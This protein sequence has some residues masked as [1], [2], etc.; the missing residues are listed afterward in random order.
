MGDGHKGG[1]PVINLAREHGMD[2]QEAANKVVPPVVFQLP[3]RQVALFLSRLIDTDGHIYVP[4]G[5]FLRLVTPRLAGSWP[6]GC[7]GFCCGWGAVGNSIPS[8]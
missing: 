6:W 4:E 5:L 2:G 3:T 7:R 8:G 1:N